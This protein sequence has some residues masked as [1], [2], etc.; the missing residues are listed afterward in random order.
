VRDAAE[1]QHR[2]DVQPVDA[3]AEVQTQFGAMTR[4]QRADDFAAGYD[5]AR[6]ERRENGFIARQDAAGM[7]DRQDILIN[8][9]AGKVHD[10]VRWRV[11]RAAGGD[12]DAAVTR[13]VGSRR[14]NERAKNLVRP[15]HG[16]GPAGFRCC[17]GRHNREAAEHEG[18]KEREAKHPLIVAKRGNAK[19]ESTRMAHNP[20]EMRP[21]GERC[22]SCPSI[23]HHRMTTRVR[24]PVNVASLHMDA[25]NHSVP[26]DSLP[27]LVEMA[28]PCAGTR[29]RTTR[30]G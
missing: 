2:R 30:C 7:G 18:N 11:D 22:Y 24:Y 10:A 3:H 8:H 5:I 9:Q 21:V 20:P 28:W 1:K 17:G 6:R 13:R 12:V 29:F 25:H 15:A 16:P 27:E 14:R 26:L 4:L 19:N 23:Q